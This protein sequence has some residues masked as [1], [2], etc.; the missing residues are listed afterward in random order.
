MVY[1]PQIKPERG[2]TMKKLALVFAAALALTACTAAPT[3]TATVPAATEPP[4]EAA[5]A[6]D[7]AT[8]EQ[9]PVGELR[10]TTFDNTNGAALYGGFSSG[11]NT[12]WTV[13]RLDYATGVQSKLCDLTFTDGLNMN[14]MIT[15]GENEVAF[16]S[17]EDDT[18]HRYIIVRPDGTTDDHTISRAF[19]PTVYDE[20]AAYEV[21]G[22]SCAR[23]DLNTGEVT[24]F[25]APL[26]Q[27]A[28]VEGVVDN[29]LLVTRI[30][31]DTPLPAEGEDEEM[32]E[33]ILQNSLREYD[34]YD[35]ATNT[36]E[37]LFDEP[38]YPEDGSSSWKTYEGC[39]GGT[40]YFVHTLWDRTTPDNTDN[41]LLTYDLA[42]G[43]WQELCTLTDKQGSWCPGFSKNGQ[44]EYVLLW[45]SADTLTL[46][47]LADGTTY[48]V[49]YQVPAGGQYGTGKNYGWPLDLTGD[50]RILVT[51]GYA[52]QGGY[53]TDGYALV[54][55]DDYLAGSTDYQPVQMWEE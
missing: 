48:D 45:Q 29:R 23:L 15:M 13:L 34:L 16:C 28:S 5:T 17:D 3:E 54:D 21:N 25:T 36:V 52:R 37:K 22:T 20:Y 43:T 44:L 55:V 40:L 31:S 4:A 7:S 27:L 26:L 39:R 47:N 32:R 41:T 19:T 49:P 14:C 33:A 38:Y 53:A 9:F 10:L 46:Y 18:Q 24:D 6:E 1:Y 42:S 35:L 51:D 2:I 50:G 30:V 8:A 11:N 12:V